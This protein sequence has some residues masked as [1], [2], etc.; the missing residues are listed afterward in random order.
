MKVCICNDRVFLGGVES[1]LQSMAEYFF[2][3]G[4]DVT[5]LAAPNDRGDFAK[6]FN[7]KVHC[8]QSRWPK[9]DYKGIGIRKTVNFIIRKAY[10]FF[11]LIWLALNRSM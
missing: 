2:D 1:I 4:Y 6:A 8:V 9:K 10:R 3:K 11:I 5:V 7:S